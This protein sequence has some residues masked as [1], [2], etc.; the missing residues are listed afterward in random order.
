MENR[1]LPVPSFY[2]AS[3]VGTIYQ[4]PYQERATQA[5]DWARQHNILPAASDSPKVALMLIDPQN[6]FCIPTGELF[7]GGRSGNGAVEDNNRL[8]QYIYRNLTNITSLI[9]TMDTHRNFAIFHPIFWVNDSGDNPGPATM[10]SAAQVRNG[11]WKVNPAAAGVFGGNYML[12]QSYALDYVETL[13]ANNR[14]ALTVWPFHALLGGIGHAIASALEEAV[15]FHGIARHALPDFQIKGGNPLTEN[16]SIFGAEVRNTV[17]HAQKNTEFLNTLLTYD[18]V[19]IAGQAKSHCLSWSVN[20]LL[21][22]IQ[23]KDASL[24]RKVYLLEDG[25]SPVVIPGIID[26]TDMAN[27]AFEKFRNAGMN[28]TTTQTPIY[29]L[30]AGVV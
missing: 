19:L 27:E 29:E 17:N 26:F 7:V 28:I 6:T 5:K 18:L 11:E 3:K 20:D 22:E 14:Y 1:T 25:T 2:D 21:T 13:E 10:I 16:Y 8:S 15:F 4:V 9:I 12:L 30:L 24:V 23:A